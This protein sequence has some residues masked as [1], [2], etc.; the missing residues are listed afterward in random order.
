MGTIAARQAREI[1]ENVRH[2]L[3]IELL[4]AA[5]GVDFLP[6]RPGV[7]TAAAY[8][9]LRTKVTHLEEDRLLSPDIEAVHSTLMDESLVRCV[10]TAIGALN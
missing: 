2:I 8:D 1:L 6:H 7:G 5:Q 4:A 3:A 10:E 9:H